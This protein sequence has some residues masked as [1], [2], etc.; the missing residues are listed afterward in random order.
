M[1]VVDTVRAARSKAFSTMGSDQR[2][3]LASS[4]I[5]QSCKSV[6]SLSGSATHFFQATCACALP[7]VK[8]GTGQPL[9]AL[10]MCNPVP[11]SNAAQEIQPRSPAQTIRAIPRSQRSVS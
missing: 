3:S 4:G 7:T 5:L 1:T 6:S 2:S 9:A 11:C 8:R 10:L